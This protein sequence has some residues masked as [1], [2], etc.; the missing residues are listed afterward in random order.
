VWFSYPRAPAKVSQHY[1]GLGFRLWGLGSRGGFR[2]MI[3]GL[4]C[5]F[6][7]LRRRVGAGLRVCCSGV[8]LCG[9]GFRLCSFG[10]RFCGFGFRFLWF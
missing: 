9:Y 4:G 8:R 5:G 2:F 10:L 1:H 3:Y 6:Y 7:G